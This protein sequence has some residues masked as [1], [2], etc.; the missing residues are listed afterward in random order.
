MTSYL[1]TYG[2]NSWGSSTQRGN[3]NSGFLSLDNAN[4]R[5]RLQ[6]AMRKNTQTLIDSANA[7]DASTKTTTSSTTT[8]STK[9]ST[10]TTTTTTPTTTTSSTTTYSSTTTPASTTTYST[11]TTPVVTTPASTTT[12][13][14]TTT[15]TITTPAVTTPA[16]TSALTLPTLP[17]LTTDLSA[18]STTTPTATTTSTATTPTT[19][20]NVTSY[21]AT[22]PTS[23]TT[24]FAFST[25]NNLMYSF[26]SMMMSMANLFGGNA[27]RAATSPFAANTMMNLINGGNYISANTN[28]LDS[29]ITPSTLGNSVSNVIPNDLSSIGSSANNPVIAQSSGSTTV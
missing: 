8:S 17:S 29:I 15:P 1:S 18:Y 5:R 12:Y 7:A 28:T 22:T 24:P 6:E 23:L 11:T 13:S 16:I 10:T 3:V 26:M 14:T 21:S 27:L 25:F 20:P 2:G 9:T 4:E 19:I